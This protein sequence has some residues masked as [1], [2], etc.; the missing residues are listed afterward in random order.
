MSLPPVPL[1]W[2]LGLQGQLLC[3]ETLATPRLYLLAG[4]H[5]F[6]GSWL[7]KL[8][9]HLGPL[10]SSRSVFTKSAGRGAG[11]GPGESL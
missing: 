6:M 7:A 10:A 11:E 1:P 8:F 5:C 2:A 3:S 9:R 4:S